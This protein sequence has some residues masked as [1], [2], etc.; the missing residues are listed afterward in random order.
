MTLLPIAAPTTPSNGAGGVDTTTANGDFAALLALVAGTVVPPPAAPVTPDEAVPEAD[1]LAPPADPV[2]PARDEPLPQDVVAVAAAP[3]QLAVPCDVRPRPASPRPL[4]DRPAMGVQVPQVAVDSSPA[5][6]ETPPPA[7]PVPLAPLAPAG[8]TPAPPASPGETTLPAPPVVEAPAPPARVESPPTGPGETSTAVAT[9]VD[10]TPDHPPLQVAPPGRGRPPTPVAPGPV[11]TAAV[12]A[13]PGAPARI[14]RPS[15]RVPASPAGIEAS[16]VLVE[17]PL[18]GQESPLVPENLVPATRVPEK[19]LPRIDAPASVPLPTPV[20][21]AESTLP[22]DA[23]APA[24]AAPPA[25]PEQIVSAVVPLHGRGDGR[26]EVT[27]E[28]RPHDLGTIRVEV[29]V[30][31]Q[32]VHLTLHAAEPATGRLL[33]AALADLRSALADAGLQA[34]HLAVSPDG[35]GATARRP[36]PETPLPERRSATSTTPETAGTSH[37]SESRPAASGRLDLL[38]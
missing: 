36:R 32:T 12:A 37:V 26:H 24:R 3:V 7:S 4:P 21:R 27:L 19:P 31:Q 35:G 14:E 15:V 16:P 23:P 13:P 5:L 30:E 33:S 9:A 11:E 6:V 34:G 8:G 17:A 20:A 2:E 18:L 28:L 10:V 25:V 22:V 1:A 38:L 29:S